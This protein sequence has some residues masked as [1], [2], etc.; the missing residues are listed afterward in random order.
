MPA[1]I[2]L[3]ESLKT[4]NGS[5]AGS[6]TRDPCPFVTRIRDELMEATPVTINRRQFLTGVLGG[7]AA[8]GLVRFSGHGLAAEHGR[9]VGRR[10]CRRTARSCSLPCTAATTGSIRSSRTNSGTYY[11]WRGE[12]AIPGEQVLHLGSDGP[13]DFGFHPSLTALAR[14]VEGGQGRHHQRCRVPQ[15]QLQP[16]PSSYIWQTAQLSGD[17]STGWLGRWLDATGDRPVPGP[18]DRP[19]PAARAGRGQ[20]AGQ[21]SGRLDF[22]WRLS[23]RGRTRSSA[24]PTDSS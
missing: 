12:L 23:S 11:D 10:P 13:H 15:P 17:P 20:A 21:L 2:S 1:L 7:S 22:A 6:T 8:A 4:D 18:V 5:V 19:E 16:L 24:A 9:G 14:P 3:A